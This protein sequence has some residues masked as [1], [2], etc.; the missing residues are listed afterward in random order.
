MLGDILSALTAGLP[1]I[2]SVTST[3]ST[4]GKV[5]LDAIQGAPGLVKALYTNDGSA[6]VSNSF[7]SATATLKEVDRM[8]SK[9]TT[10]QSQ[11][12]EM[13]DISKQLQGAAV[14]IGDRLNAGLW[15]LMSDQAAFAAFASSGEF[16]G[17]PGLS[18]PQEVDGISA[19]LT[20]FILSKALV[21][22]GYILAYMPNTVLGSGADRDFC[23]YDGKIP[24]SCYRNNTLFGGTIAY[25]GKK[26]TQVSNGW[27]YSPVKVMKTIA[28]NNWASQQSLYQS[29][30]DC[31]VSG[32]FGQ[33]LVNI[34]ADGTV[35]FDCIS[36]L[37]EC[38]WASPLDHCDVNGM[39][40]IQN[41]PGTPVSN[42]KR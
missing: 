28:D 22:S 42:T 9:L 32:N 5:F 18:L 10:L 11:L 29:A 13:A 12:I 27:D 25:L 26:S 36:Q 41:C 7:Q 3:T 6:E 40:P 4:V 35:N 14:N 37:T 30:F 23:T 1:F 19:A 24:D 17:D 16:S 8:R 38:F 33:N 2:G 31:A 21:D 20:I 34:H 15:N 39:C